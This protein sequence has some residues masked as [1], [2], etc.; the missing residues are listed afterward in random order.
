MSGG[1]AVLLAAC[2][3]VW[4][5]AAGCGGTVQQ[6]G[7]KTAER[8]LVVYCPHQMSLIKPVIAAFEHESG[9]GVKVIR[10]GTGELLAKLQSE[11]DAPQCDVLWG[12]AWNTVQ[13]YGDLF[14]DYRTANADMMQPE[15][16]GEGPFIW[17]SDLPSVMMANTELMGGLEMR[18]YADLLDPALKGRI[19]MADPAKS[20]AAYEHLVNMLYAMGNG[21]PEAGWL[22]VAAFAEQLDGKLLDS[23]YAV[24]K[25]VA[26]G[27]YVVGLTFEEGAAKCLAD[28]APVRVIYMKEGVISDPDGVFIIKGT[29]QR[30]RAEQFVDF[31]TGKEVQQMLPA[32]LHRR[33]VRSDVS[34]PSNLPAKEDINII[35]DD[36]SVVNSHKADW[37]E[38]FHSLLAK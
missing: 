28:G 15:F 19:A 7:Q 11:K 31:L 27:E 30:E 35:Y 3:A 22:Y 1:R 13:P 26:D 14:E 12:G 10:G 25:G 38:R 24:Y 17:F 32:Q 23:S 2:L 34:S 5:L 21:D 9:I 36:K 6:D 29:G 8:E 20:S 18:G 4:M 16:R 33:S 37:I